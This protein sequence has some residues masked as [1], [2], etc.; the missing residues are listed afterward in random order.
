MSRRALSKLYRMDN[1]K[2][3]GCYTSDMLAY[4]RTRVLG[5]SLV[6]TIPREVVRQEDLHPGELVQIQVEKPK[7]SFFGAVK[8]IGPFTKEDE[9]DTHD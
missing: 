5:G 1:F 6:V 3:A 2:Y 8:G 4:A 9:L 7:K